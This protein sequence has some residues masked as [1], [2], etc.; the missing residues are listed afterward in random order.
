MS[1]RPDTIALRASPFSRTFRSNHDAWSFLCY[2][3]LAAIT[4][5]GVLGTLG[6]LPLLMLGPASLP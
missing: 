1:R 2:G 5:P 3:S 4:L 6:H